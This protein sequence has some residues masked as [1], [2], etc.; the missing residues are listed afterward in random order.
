VAGSSVW[1]R[2]Y[3]KAIRRKI[4]DAQLDDQISFLSEVPDPDLEHLFKQSHLLVVP[5]SFEGFG[6]VYLE[7]M[8]FGLPAIASQAGGTAEVVTH[9]VNGYLVAP[10]D[11]DTLG[12]HIRELAENRERLLEMSLAARRAFLKHP[13][14]AHTGKVI[15]DFL[16]NF[17]A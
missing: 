5:S 11:V 8:G 15:H 4:H 14:W 10:G 1:D 16:H 12:S 2:G 6:I 13:S 3:A 17:K 9:G 7:G